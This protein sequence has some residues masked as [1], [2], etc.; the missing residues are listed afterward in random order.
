MVLHQSSDLINNRGNG[1]LCV[2]PCVDL[3]CSVELLRTY[4]LLE[5]LH[6]LS[7]SL[8]SLQPPSPKK[9][10]SSAD[11]MA[12]DHTPSRQQI[13]TLFSAALSV[14]LLLTP[15]S[16]SAWSL[17]FIS[18]I[19]RLYVPCRGC[20][21]QGRITSKDSITQY[22]S[23]DDAPDVR[24]PETDLKRLVSQMGTTSRTASTDKQSPKKQSR[25][26]YQLGVGKNLPIGGNTTFSSKGNQDIENVASYIST[27]FV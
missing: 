24:R 16:S 12:S 2:C 21:L 17:A 18:H 13:M 22:A 19:W 11:N 23:S 9:L 5:I 15:L 6:P 8:L 25:P 4:C 10:C 3:H 20:S 26:R 27:S 1:C 14:L 7:L